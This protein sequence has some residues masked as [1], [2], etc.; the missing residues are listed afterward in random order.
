[1]KPLISIIVPAYNEEKLIGKC[2]DSLKNQSFPKENY[3][4]LVIDNNST[5]RTSEIAKKC[6]VRVVAYKEKQGFSVTKQFGAD[7]ASGEIIAFCDADT[8]HDQNWLHIISDLFRDNNLKIIGGSALPSEG[9]FITN[10]LYSIFDL[11]AQINQVFGNSLI[12]GFNM[13]IRKNAFIK[14]GGFN[15]NLTSGE[16]WDISV[17]IR[18]KYGKGSTLYTNKMRTKTS[19]RKVS[20]LSSSLPYFFW[21]L[22]NYF[23]IFISRQ[24][25][26][27]GKSI[28]IR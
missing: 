23:S 25:V 3:E 8:F 11:F 19:P 28:T 27:F 9:S 10:A 2:L 24:S 5:D 13:A 16:D 15:L 17:R 21:G 18:E 26:S 1:M 7:L 4:I 14:V 20:S 12:W 22:V 6:G